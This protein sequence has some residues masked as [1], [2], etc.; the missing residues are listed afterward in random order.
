MSNAAAGDRCRKY[1]RSRSSLDPNLADT[2]VSIAAS[3]GDADLFDS[4]VSE[5]KSSRTPQEQRRFLMG[6]CDFTEPALVDRTLALLLSDA[7]PTQ[8]VAF[9]VVRLLGN[10][11]ARERTWSFVQRRWPKLQRRMASLLA[12]RVISATPAL[13]T[14]AYRREVARFFKANPIPAGAR[15]LRQA[16][17]RFDWYEEFRKRESNALD[18]YLHGA[19]DA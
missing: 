7:V 5:M 14:P 17:E 8:D 18:A 2:V 10:R 1:L 15:A 16:L 3:H 9:V 6:L 13:A 12:A 19:P 11:S 4:F